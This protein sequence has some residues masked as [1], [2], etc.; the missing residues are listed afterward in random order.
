MQISALFRYYLLAYRREQLWLPVALWSLFVLLAFLFRQ[1]S[2]GPELGVAFLGFIVP[3]ISGVL[4]ASIIVD[5]PAL[6]VQLAA[7]K[8]AWQILVE[9]LA[10]MLAIILVIALTYQVVLV[11]VGVDISYL[12]GLAYRQMAWLAPTVSAMALASVS[13]FLFVQGTFGAM[14]IGGIWI[15]QL[16]LRGWFPTH[17]VAKYFFWFMGANNPGHPDL[18]L[19]QA[20]LLVTAVVL[21]ALASLLLRK[22]ERY[23]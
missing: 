2:R 8:R 10:L 16:L 12:G 15:I 18:R 14:L 23:I 22:E 3:L 7:P 4:A 19:N 1:D 11:A 9:R 6:E 20:S 21:T 13:A 17:P 5:D